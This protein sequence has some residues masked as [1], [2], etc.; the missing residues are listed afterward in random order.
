MIVNKYT[1]MIKYLSMIIKIDVAKLIKLFLKKLFYVSIYQQILLIIK[2]FFI[3]VFWLTFCYHAK[4]K[5]WLN[6]IFYSQTNE[7][8]ERQN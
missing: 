1:K 5:C 6:T 4:I 3:N 7:Q 2:T 8:T